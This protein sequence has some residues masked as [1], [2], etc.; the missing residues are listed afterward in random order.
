MSE[1]KSSV[2]DINRL[3]MERYELLEKE[4]SS[5]IVE[6]V[7]EGIAEG[8]RSGFLEGLKECFDIGFLNL[9][10]T[11]VRTLDEIARDIAS[12]AV[13]RKARE[14]VMSEVCPRLQVHL[15]ELCQEAV[16]N[17]IKEHDIT[18]RAD[19]D[20]ILKEL[21]IK[22]ILQEK[23]EGAEKKV[24]DRLPPHF[25]VA[26]FLDGLTGGITQCLNESIDR[27][28]Q[29]V[30]EALHRKSGEADSP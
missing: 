28:V 10:T 9:K 5:A 17:L 20:A 25:L 29:K 7:K 24:K 12:D 22:K 21:K 18:T 11:R 4:I 13:E 8:T 16:D 26:S 6:G 2:E 27:C 30:E 1:S 3:C 23:M 14:Q 15:N 19:I